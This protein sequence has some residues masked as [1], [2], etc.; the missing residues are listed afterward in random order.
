MLIFW[1]VF[2]IVMV[3]IDVFTSAFLFV[4]FALGGAAA[5]IANLLGF[6]M[7]M[8]IIFFGVVSII[9]ILIGY[10]WAKKK[11]KT[12]IKPIPLMEETYV[13]KE[14]IADENIEKTTRLKVGGIYWTGCNEGTP[15][16]KGQK[17]KIVGV[18]GNKL[19]IKGFE[20]ESNE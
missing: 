10:P 11:F 3:L 15:I 6:N 2:S 17:F 18:E 5:I 13:G 4:W 14:F 8:Q 20:E 1:L 16:K 19:M 12:S 7:V 9:T